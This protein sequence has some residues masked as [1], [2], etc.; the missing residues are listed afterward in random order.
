MWITTAI[1]KILGKKVGIAPLVYFRVAFGLAMFISSLRFI[2]K[3][4]VDTLLIQPS[5]R[6]SYFG[7]DWAQVPMSTE[8]AYGL[9]GI[10]VLCSLGILLGFRFRWSATLFA[11]AFIFTEFQ[12]ASLYLNHY[13]FISWVALILPFTPANQAFSIDHPRASIG[14][15]IDQV[16]PLFF[17]TLLFVV[18]FFAGLAKL[19]PDWIIDANPLRI[20]LPVH[21][22]MPLIG[23]MLAQKS[24]ALIASWL[25]CLFDLSVGF[26]LF[27]PT[28]RNWA[29]L[30]VVL[31]HA[32][33]G[34]LF[35][36]GVFPLVMVMLTP[37][38]FTAQSHEKWQAKLISLNGTNTSVLRSK[39]FITKYLFLLFFG[40]NLFFP[41]RFMLYP[42]SLFWTEQGYRFSWRVMLMEK[43]GYGS[44]WLSSPAS[45][46]KWNVDP[47]DY[48][49]P[50]QEKQLYTQPDFILQFARYLKEQH[51]QFSDLEVRANIFVTLNGENSVSFI[52]PSV[53]LLAENDGWHHKTWI[54]QA[55]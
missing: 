52:N 31:F 19:H 6:F 13:Y 55:P 15:K 33:T 24:T 38:F 54:T 18:Y 16:W 44:F 35:N 22:E 36:I 30:S 5:F 10:Q 45:D 4:W 23:A 27:I 48:L 26:L 9:L 1:D 20:W 28:T 49:M 3:G 40:L 43:S 39:L 14:I 12:D 37:L 50:H 32:F 34:L 7:F 29:Y 25:G 47:A 41:V 51:P 42:G 17:K 11:L 46:R 53:N 21:Q 2:Y 8:L